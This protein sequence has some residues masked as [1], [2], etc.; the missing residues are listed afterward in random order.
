MSNKISFEITT[1]ERTV[2]K[3]EDVEEVSLPTRT[4]EITILPH[5][6]PLVSALVPGE[7]R[8]KKDQKIQF[9]A[10]SGGFIEVQP[11]SK[12]VVLADTAE[13]AEEINIEVVEAAKRK[14]EELIKQKH[15]NDVEYTALAAQMERELARLRVARKHRRQHAG[16]EGL[17]EE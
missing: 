12:V 4:G 3:A 1:P 16:F 10:V 14:A 9:L 5:H 6:I 17:K 2:F 11:N 15:L 13:R 7:V 8:I